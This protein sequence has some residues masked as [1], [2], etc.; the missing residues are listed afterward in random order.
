MKAIIIYAPGDIRY[1]EIAKPK[2]GPREVLTRVVY[3]GIC[4]TDLEI[5]HGDTS[6]AKNGLIHYPVR[7]GHEWSG[8]VEEVGSEVTDFK[9]GDRV[10][11][12]TGSSCGQCEA[13]LSGHFKSCRNLISLGTVETHKEGAFAEYMLMH[14]WHMHHVPDS[15]GLDEA[16]LIEPATIAWNGLNNCQIRP[17][18]NIL[19]IGTGAIGLTAVGLAKYQ[20]AGKVM[21]AG[22]K[23]FKLDVGKKVGA[24]AVVNVTR[25]NLLDFVMRET[26][27]SGVDVFFETSGAA[28]YVAQS[29]DMMSF[30]GTIALVG[31][32]EDYLNGFDLNRLVMGARKLIGCEGTAWSAPTVID[33]AR[34]GK[35]ILKPLITHIIPFDQAIEAMRTARQNTDHKIKML[36]KIGKE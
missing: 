24:D 23:D 8:I 4:G 22:R 26:G 20:K 36:V 17:G 12:D 16:A 35:L 34:Q 29:L 30:N 21:L 6:L 15:I 32:Y 27:D 25:E 33:I 18:S 28:E 10:I 2:P 31:F 14:H 19:I 1:A 7:I 11:S 13:C 5:L 3:C 9:P